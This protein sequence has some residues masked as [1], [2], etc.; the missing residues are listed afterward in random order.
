MKTGYDAFIDFIQ[1]SSKAFDND[2]LELL[3]STCSN[4]DR[5]TQ[6][7]FQH[8]DAGRK[9]ILK[10]RLQ[11][12]VSRSQTKQQRAVFEAM[13][14]ILNDNMPA[15]FDIEGRKYKRCCGAN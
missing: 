10:E 7:G 6:T 2:S 5:T 3:E 14:D 9:A 12:S 4:T 11:Y 1:G 15:A 13:L 8:I